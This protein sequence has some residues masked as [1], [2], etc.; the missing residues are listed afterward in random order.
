ME[1][2][3]NHSRKSNTRAKAAPKAGCSAVYFKM[4]DWAPWRSMGNGNGIFMG[5]D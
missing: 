4:K 5:D 2:T 3:F 1:T